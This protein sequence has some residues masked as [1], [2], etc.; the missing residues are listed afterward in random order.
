MFNVEIWGTVS[1]WILTV[2]AGGTALVAWVQ[3]KAVGRAAKAQIESSAKDTLAQ[4]TA[5]SEAHNKELS[6]ALSAARDQ[7]QI[8]RATLLLEI[9][10]DYEAPEMLESRLAL[11][12]LRNEIEAFVIS[13]NDALGKAELHVALN[14]AFGTYLNKLWLD[15]KKADRPHASDGL[16]SL[17]RKHLDL[18]N[19]EPAKVQP[20]ERAGLHYQRL[21]R[22][23]G[24]L[25]RVGYMAN[26][27]LLPQDDIKQL[28][29]FVFIELGY[30]FEGHIRF[31]QED[32]PLANPD[33]MKEFMTFRS[34]LLANKQ[35]KIVEA[36]PDPGGV[37]VF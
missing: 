32:G 35:P 6:A 3:L 28:Y 15:F 16:D 24:W 20:H 2:L 37:S 4:I 19:S 11:R 25:E 21:S 10:R 9:D 31:R 17:L 14:E 12:G 5:A 18:A 30:W 7:A 8:A 22:V 1:D 23:L 36:E 26:R 34:M 27:K 29:D 33:F 13:K